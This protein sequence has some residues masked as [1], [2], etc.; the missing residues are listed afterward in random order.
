MAGKTPLIIE[1]KTAGKNAAALTEAVCNQLGNYKGLYCIES[2]DP[3]CLRWLRKNRPEIIRGQLSRNFFK[4]KNNP[5]NWF[6]KL[7][8][9]LQILNFYTRPDFVAYRFA[10]RKTL[11]NRLVKKLWGAARV[12][13]T[14]R[15]PEDCKLARQEGWIP[16]FENFE[17]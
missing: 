14:I 17:P 15:D 7:I 16:I 2:F 11:G 1:L 12:A 8:M 5:L 4:A 6:F 3:R 13:W 10:D 9:T